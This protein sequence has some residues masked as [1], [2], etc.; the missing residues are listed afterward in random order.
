MHGAARLDEQRVRRDARVLAG[1]LP[2]LLVEHRARC[3]RIVQPRN[4]IGNEHPASPLIDK[5]LAPGVDHD[6]GNAE[7]VALRIRPYQVVPECIALQQMA[8]EIRELAGRSPIGARHAKSITKTIRCA[9]LH[10]LAGLR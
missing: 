1:A 9:A 3:Q 2:D 4:G 6:T 8:V 7:L 5:S 10:E